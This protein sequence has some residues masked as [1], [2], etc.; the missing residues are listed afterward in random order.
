MTQ[1]GVLNRGSQYQTGRC[2]AAA[3]RAAR[4]MNGYTIPGVEPLSL[5]EKVGIVILALLI[6][7]TLFG[8]AGLVLPPRL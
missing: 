1:R 6:A 2:D 5:V 7:L 8:M 4:L 3:R